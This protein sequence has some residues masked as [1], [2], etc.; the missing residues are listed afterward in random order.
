MDKKELIVG[1]EVEMEHIGFNEVMS[2][3]S[4]TGDEMV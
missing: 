4:P 3:I 1:I 2:W